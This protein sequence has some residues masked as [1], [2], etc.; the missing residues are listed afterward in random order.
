MKIPFWLLSCFLPLLFT[1]TFSQSKK[2]GDGTRDT[3][4]YCSGKLISIIEKDAK[5][6][7]QGK[8]IRF[9]RNGKI[10]ELS[11][12][13]LGSLD[14]KAIYF[15]ET[16]DTSAI[17]E[18]KNGVLHGKIVA[19]YPKGKK[20]LAEYAHAGKPSGQ[21]LYLDTNGLPFNGKFREF[22]PNEA[23]G[24]VRELTCVEGRPQ[25]TLSIHDEET[26]RLNSQYTMSDG[27]VQ[28][29]AYSY[30][31]EESRP[32]VSF[33][34]N[35]KY[36]KEDDS[37]Y[38]HNIKEYTLYLRADSN[39]AILYLRALAF[40]HVG[41]KKEAI[42]DLESVIHLESTNYKAFYNQGVLLGDT[43]PNKAIADFKACLK[44]KPDFY[45]AHYN[46][47]FLYFQQKN[48]KMAIDGFKRSLKY[49]ADYLPSVQYLALIYDFKKDRKNSDYY[50]KL[51]ESL[52]SK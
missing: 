32:F 44:L 1:A 31:K 3:L 13:K 48:Y 49:K 30:V 9:F 21:S 38:H 20:M 23:W 36:V 47:A 22:V 46:L 27:Y 40:L 16:G 17:M 33:F 2:A 41:N 51:A 12:Y 37:L 5:G 26:C 11:S 42:Q 6:I 18:W 29:R 28:G 10:S 45:L 4:R 14:G 19:Y 25:G 15:Y 50:W 34:E 24:N 7:P 35:G 52:E 8:T 39:A 43:L